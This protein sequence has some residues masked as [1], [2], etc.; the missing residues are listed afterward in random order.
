M[1]PN[2]PGGESRRFGL[3]PRIGDLDQQPLDLQGV[4]VEVTGET[5]NR[6]GHRRTVTRQRFGSRCFAPAAIWRV[7]GKRRSNRPSGRQPSENSWK[8]IA[9][10]LTRNPQQ[11]SSPPSPGSQVRRQTVFVSANEE[12][13]DWK[14]EKY[15]AV[16]QESGKESSETSVPARGTT[17]ADDVEDRQHER[18]SLGGSR[19]NGRTA[20]RANSATP[21]TAAEKIQMR[22]PLAQGHRLKSNQQESHARCDS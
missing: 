19:S 5:G 12:L 6:S 3:R 7:A 10:A 15:S 1:L 16:R 20:D 18:P 2:R 4:G 13:A 8:T 9:T 22:K 11:T 14:A 21:I 17:N